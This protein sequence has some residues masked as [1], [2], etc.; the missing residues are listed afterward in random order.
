VWD[1]R[2]G[3]LFAADLFLG[4]RVSVAH[5]SERP[6]QLVRS[7]RAAH[8]LGAS[9]MFDAHRG[10]V[11]DPARALSAKIAWMED[12][13]GKIETLAGRGFSE[14]AIQRELLGREGL[15]GFFSGGEYS[16]ENLIRAVLDEE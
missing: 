12:L 6:R 15:S 13:I 8:S 3:T 16:K 14:R 4:V 11:N 5:V 7:L 10:A 2:E 1:S 9:R